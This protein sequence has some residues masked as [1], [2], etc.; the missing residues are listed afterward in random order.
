ML[1]HEP[2]NKSSQETD[3]SP[4]GIDYETVTTPLGKKVRK[5]ITPNRQQ[6]HQVSS[7]VP[8]SADSEAAKKEGVS[9]KEIMKRKILQALP[10]PKQQNTKT[11][12]TDKEEQEEDED[13]EEEEEEENDEEDE[14]D[15][16]AILN[17]GG[18]KVKTPLP[19]R[20]KV[21]QEEEE[22]KEEEEEE[23]EETQKK[24]KSNNTTPSTPVKTKPP[25]A[26]VTQPQHVQP[27]DTKKSPPSSSTESAKAT[28][29]AT[30]MTKTANTVKMVDP[31]SGG[32][33]ALDWGTSNVQAVTVDPQ[34]SERI[35]VRPIQGHDND[36]KGAGTDFCIVKD[37]PLD[38][39]ISSEG[40]Y[41]EFES[42]YID[43]LEKTESEGKHMEKAADI[44]YLNKYGDAAKAVIGVDNERNAAER[45]CIRTVFSKTNG[46]ACFPYTDDKAIPYKSIFVKQIKKTF[47]AICKNCSLD[48]Q[49]AKKLIVTTYPPSYTTDRIECYRS[50]F[51]EAGFEQVKLYAESTAAAHFFATEQEG[52][53][54]KEHINNGQL[55]LVADLGSLTGGVSI[56]INKKGN[57]CHIYNDGKQDAGGRTLDI[58][59][60][61]C[62]VGKSTST[63]H[64]LANN[65]HE[66]V[67][68]FGPV[69]FKKLLS[70]SEEAKLAM[71]GKISSLNTMSYEESSRAEVGEHKVLVP[72]DKTASGYTRVA[73]TMS[74]FKEACDK[75]LS[76][77]I[78]M[79]TKAHEACV[80]SQEKITKELKSKKIK[81]MQED[82]G[83]TKKT[84]CTLILCGGTASNPLIRYGIS[85]QFEKKMGWTVLCSSA[86][87]VVAKGAM[88]LYMDE[89]IHRNPDESSEGGQQEYEEIEEHILDIL[90]SN[91][92]EPIII[93]DE[94]VILQVNAPL[95]KTESKKQKQKNNDNKAASSSSSS[96][97]ASTATTTT[98]VQKEK[99]TETAV[100]SGTK[101]KP[102]GPSGSSA[103]S[104]SKKGKRTVNNYTPIEYLTI[105]DKSESV[106]G[107]VVDREFTTLIPAGIQYPST[108]RH[109][110]K[111]KQLFVNKVLFDSNRVDFEL[112]EM[113]SERKTG[114][115]MLVIDL[116]NKAQ[117]NDKV[118]IQYTLNEHGHPTFHFTLIRPKKTGRYKE[119]EPDRV[120]TVIPLTPINVQDMFAEGGSERRVYEVSEKLNP[121][122][123]L[124]DGLILELQKD[125]VS[126]LEQIMKYLEENAADYMEEEKPVHE[127]KEEELPPKKPRTVSRSKK[128]KKRRTISDDDDDDD[129][130][131]NDDKREEYKEQEKSRP[132]KKRKTQAK[133]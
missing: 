128:G 2:T 82:L 118:Q 24:Q 106:S 10:K 59:I 114:I 66:Y 116:Q 89:Y 15:E 111:M 46:E 20:K 123:P 32:I 36:S 43:L 117:I 95:T 9:L 101:S 26:A 94:D 110:C 80:D 18:P 53:N 45:R 127:E 125:K 79:I 113:R 84:K 83:I 52:S 76:V 8:S 112:F 70:A 88:R 99:G 39:F 16:D 49:E 37:D 85:E 87:K 60:A 51:K 54:N 50:C 12:P 17:F 93:P 90:G 64:K 35:I 58:H 67:E 126:T 41:N 115:G 63:T 91:K 11:F 97:A 5:A 27:T 98:T 120:K 133:K 105:V 23:E 77:V 100:S 14:D 92:E 61:N 74:D 44:P 78:D 65:I 75:I 104:T 42:Y 22:E 29:E 71:S 3:P 129:D 130:D 56:F 122:N 119:G 73:F 121:L 69:A 81:G 108:Q 7:K 86:Q 6:Q 1:I 131:D 28:K 19:N 21:V 25:T 4:P 33:I 107:E 102:K 109:D 30:K 124:H 62:V 132:Q 13:E 40:A 55:V 34:N 47:D 38:V 103:A 72:K 68:K 48:K 96:S 57:I 31:R